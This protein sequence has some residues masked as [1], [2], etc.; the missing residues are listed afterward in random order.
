M[1]IYWLWFLKT[2]VIFREISILTY[3]T[4]TPVTPRSYSFVV[5]IKLLT[6]DKSMT[7]YNLLCSV[8][9]LL[10]VVSV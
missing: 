2:K 10:L 8:F 3:K 5:C 9:P 6:K 4:W 1:P 7:S